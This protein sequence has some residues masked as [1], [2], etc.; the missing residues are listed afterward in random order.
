DPNPALNGSGGHCFTVPAAQSKRKRTRPG[1][2][3]TR[4]QRGDQKPDTRGQNPSGL[5]NDADR[6]RKI[7]N[8]DVQP[9]TGKPV[10]QKADNPGAGDVTLFEY[11]RAAG[12]DQ[13]RGGSAEHPG[14]PAIW[15]LY[16]RPA[17][18]PG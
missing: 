2:G 17:W 4:A 18:R 16:A 12:L 10:F 9:V 13:S 7:R 15:N 8:A 5:F 14:H 6:T 3:D 1:N 11:R